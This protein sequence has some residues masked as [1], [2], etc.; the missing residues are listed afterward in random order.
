MKLVS[1]GELTIDHY[2]NL[3]RTFVG[4][5]SLNFAVQAKRCGA[6][7]VSLVSR[8][9]TDVNGAR[10]LEKLTTEG[11]DMSHVAVVRGETA[12]CFIEL[13]DGVERSYPADGYHQNVLA[14]FELSVADCAFIRQH[15]VMVSHLDYSQ[16]PTLF[17]QTMVE[18]DFRGKRIADF[19]DWA[20]YHGDH[21]TLIAYL[22]ALDIAFVSGTQAAIDRLLPVS[23]RIGGLIVVT[24]GAAGSAALHSGRERFQPALAASVLLDTTGCGDAFQA[25]FTVKYLRTSSIEQALEHG[26]AQAAEVLQH[27][28]AI[29]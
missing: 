12:N 22:D 18:L 29:G 17:N 5:I 3:N 20:D 2:L 7:V 4:G 24:L 23:V 26:A 28:G 19:G 25:A 14:G 1:V 8:V 9:G 13:I 15:D 10:A 11:V 16:S 6:E 21:D 27:Y